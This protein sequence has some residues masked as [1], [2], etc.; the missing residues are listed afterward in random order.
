M[1]E[2]GFF[3]KQP[4][5]IILKAGLK[6]ISLIKICLVWLLCAERGVAPLACPL[7]FLLMYNLLFKQFTAHRSRAHIA[8]LNSLFWV[9]YLM[10]AVRDH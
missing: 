1:N 10:M 4:L 9:T 6:I 3:H 2:Y 5:P 7:T 8:L